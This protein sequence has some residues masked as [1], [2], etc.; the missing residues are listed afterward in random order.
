M[1]SDVSRLRDET[2][3]SGD[4]GLHSNLEQVLAE[5]IACARQASTDSLAAAVALADKAPRIFVAGAGRSG[6]CMKAFG[7]RLMHLG[8]TVYVVGE[9]TTPGILA[10]D[11][12]VIGSGSGRTASLLTIASHAGQRGA[13]ILLFTTEADSPLG[14][15]AHQRVIIPAPSHHADGVERERYSAQPLGT[16][17][18]QALFILCDVLVLRL[19]QRSG[20]NSAQMADRHANLE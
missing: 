17:F 1:G 5:I 16:L 8:K 15:L 20:A 18:E 14:R 6:L 11:L 10:S 2:P 9:T 13:N 3:T 19:M 7:M 4:V 12:L